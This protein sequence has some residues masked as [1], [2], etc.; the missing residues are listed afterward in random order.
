MLWDVLTSAKTPSGYTWVSGWHF[1]GLG[2]E[3]SASQEPLRKS[4]WKADSE[5]IQPPRHCPDLFSYHSLHSP[6]IPPP[7]FGTEL[8]ESTLGR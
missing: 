1:K 4:L 8:G 6:S 2:T 7:A 3:L 5:G